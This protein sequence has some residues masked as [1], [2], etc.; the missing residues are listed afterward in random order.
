[1]QKEGICT[2]ACVAPV[3]SDLFLVSCDGAIGT[4]IDHSKVKKIMR[5]ANNCLVLDCAQLG[6]HDSIV[7]HVAK[8]FR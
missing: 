2:R 8:T 1:M 7:H 6:S 5:Y 3:L 4:C